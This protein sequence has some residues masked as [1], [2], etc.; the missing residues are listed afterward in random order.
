MGVPCSG[1]ERCLAGPAGPRD[2]NYL[3]DCRPAPVS[4]A[5]RVAILRTLPHE[6]AVAKLASKDRAKLDSLESVL[7]LHER[8][9][10]Y[11][12]KIIDVPQAWSGLHG[13][14]V[15]LVSLPALQL[16]SREQLQSL[17]AHEIGHEYWW[18]AWGAA[19]RQGDQNRLRIL[20]ALCDAVA[21]L[22]LTALGIPAERLSSALGAVLECAIHANTGTSLI[23]A[24]RATAGLSSYGP[25]WDARV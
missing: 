1:E 14:A 5:E 16:L 24:L 2:L 19:H 17:V 3:A 20:E 4:A 10:V 21:V 15:L 8:D 6:G 22:T 13:R 18:E 11:E 25:R 12:V 9:E 7:R 23:Q